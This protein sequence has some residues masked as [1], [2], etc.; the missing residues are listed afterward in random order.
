MLNSTRFRWASMQ[1]QYLCSFRFDIDI[2]NSLGRGPPDLYTLYG[3]IYDVLSGIPGDRRAKVFKNVLRWLLCAQTT[4]HTTKF[5]AMVSVDPGDKTDSDPIAI[6]DVLEI[7]NNF[8]VLDD[9]LDRFRFAHSSVREFLEQRLNILE[10]NRLMAELCLWSVLSQE[11]E[12]AF[13]GLLDQL[14]LCASSVPTDSAMSRPTSEILHGY[15]VI[16]W[17]THCRLAEDHREL[18]CGALKTLLRHM[19]SHEPS[20]Y[21]WIDQLQAS[22]SFE[23]CDRGVQEQL[24]ATIT[25]DDSRLLAYDQGRRKR[26]KIYFRRRPRSSS[27]FRLSILEVCC[28][29]DLKEQIEFVLG[30]Q[31]PGRLTP[32]EHQESLWLAAKYGSSATI[33]QLLMTKHWTNMEIS[34][35]AMDTALRN[36]NNAKELITLFSSHTGGTAAIGEEELRAAA[37]SG[38]AVVSLLLLRRLRR[39]ISVTSEGVEAAAGNPAYGYHIM[40]EFLDQLGADFKITTDVVRAAQGNTRYSNELLLLL[41]DRAGPCTPVTLEIVKRAAGDEHIEQQV[42]LRLLD[43]L[44]ADT[45]IT[46]DLVKTAAGNRGIGKEVMHRLLDQLGAGTPVTLDVVE[47]AADNWCTEKEVMLL[48][49]GRLEASASITAKLTA[50]IVR[51]QDADVIEFLLD[52]RG[53]D[54]QITETIVIAAV[55]PYEN[56]TQKKMAVLLKRLEQSDA[57]ITVGLMALVV[58]HCQEDVIASLLDQRGTDVPIAEEVVRALAHRPRKEAERILA[59]LLMHRKQEMY[60]VLVRF[61]DRWGERPLETLNAQLARVKI[62]RTWIYLRTDRISGDL[63]V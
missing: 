42:M 34:S 4:L 55:R 1:L 19:L 49:L 60:E 2:A 53:L 23:Y 12:V 10:A 11:D 33:Q 14:K 47:T 32:S 35:L 9:Q 40:R 54:I 29:F 51:C 37:D 6:E 57:P 24:C 41:L 63:S 17:P 46:L 18:P 36:K 21:R 58:G 30:D 56:E 22:R 5:L 39:D 31:M 43:Q 7:C 52:Q 27:F 26:R 45:T 50:T 28:A 3:D 20:F 48:L 38:E 16:Y 25:L 59:V 62:D 15:A 13:T 61:W 8:V 44:G